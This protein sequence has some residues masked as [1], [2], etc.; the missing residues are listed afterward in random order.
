MLNTIT[1]MAGCRS[2]PMMRLLVMAGVVLLVL[3]NSAC[4]TMKPIA[5]EDLDSVRPSQAWITK[6]DE[7]VVV[8]AGPQIV[9]NRLA[10]F[11]NGTYQVMPMNEVKQ[12]TVRRPARGK[13]AALI[14][15]GA[16]GTAVVVYMISGASGNTDPCS[17][18]SS[19]CLERPQ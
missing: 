19:E 1:K 16:V 9:R 3:A 15:V 5:L 13:T 12:V 6:T 14:A 8:V 17:L 4:H 10:G 11:V 7:S 18:Q 2:V